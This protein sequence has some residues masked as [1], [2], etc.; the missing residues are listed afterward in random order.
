MKKFFKE[1]FGKES[2]GVRYN[3]TKQGYEK[4]QYGDEQFVFNTKTNKIV[5]INSSCLYLK[6]VFLQSSLVI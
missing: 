5:K 3:P 2:F 6:N 4:I 1:L